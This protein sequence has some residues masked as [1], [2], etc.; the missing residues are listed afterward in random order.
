MVILV[1]DKAKNYHFRSNDNSRQKLKKHN[2]REFQIKFR[3]HLFWFKLSIFETSSIRS[4]IPCSWRFLM[5][6]ITNKNGSISVQNSIFPKFR[7]Q[8]RHN[9]VK[10]A[11]SSSIPRSNDP[12]WPK[13]SGIRN[14]NLR[15]P[16]KRPDIVSQYWYQNFQIF[17]K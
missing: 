4:L 14:S 16:L 11:D 3:G 17:G 12:F 5:G 9:L 10:F 1:N 15:F 6:V 2:N 13:T 8:Y 7:P